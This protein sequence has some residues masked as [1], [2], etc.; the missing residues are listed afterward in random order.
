MFNSL[1]FYRCAVKTHPFLLALLL[2]MLACTPGTSGVLEI[3]DDTTS[4]TERPA[5]TIDSTHIPEEP[6]AP[7]PST[8]DSHS[9]PEPNDTQITRRL[10]LWATYYIVHAAEAVVDGIPLID[11][12]NNPLGP[13]LT[14]RDWCD[15][16][17]EGTVVVSSE[18]GPRV[19]NYADHNGPTQADCGRFYSSLSTAVIRGTNR[20]RFLE[21]DTPYGLGVR[22][23][24]LNP[25]RTIAVDRRVIPYGTVVYIPAARGLSF[26]SPSGEVM[27]H[28]GYFYA[29]DTGGAIRGHH[30]DVFGGLHQGRLFPEFIKS[31]ETGTFEAFIIQNEAIQA[32][33]DAMHQK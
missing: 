11:K 16:A 3:P 33:L 1:F 26:P 6:T 2:G 9:F 24:H 8:E 31:V 13:A 4:T 19:Y 21:T 14:E 27:H 10:E 12:D 30:I 5:D 15:A 32:A 25:Y 17:V 23:W 28:D 29:G 20:V 22:G 7:E 18:D